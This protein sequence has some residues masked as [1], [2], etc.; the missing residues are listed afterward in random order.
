M[1]DLMKIYAVLTILV[2]QLVGL[3]AEEVEV[4]LDPFI[5]IPAAFQMS[6]QS[7]E[8]SFRGAFRW[9]NVD[10]TRAIFKRKAY[11]GSS[12]DLSLLE[13][14]VP[15]DEL[16]VDF[17]DGRFL[18]CSISIFNRGDSGSLS[19]AEFTRRTELI[20]QYL[21]Q[22]LKASPISR[23]SEFSKAVKTSGAI[24]KSTIGMAALE[25]NDTAPQGTV[26]SLC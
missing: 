4:S 7:M 22:S 26:S 5:A 17:K 8:A 14:Q 25:Y 15:V 9:L 21:G 10:K 1:K 3:K 20:K 13:K 2:L 16:I 23:R 18:G 12:F 19:G 24:W 6:P 11:N